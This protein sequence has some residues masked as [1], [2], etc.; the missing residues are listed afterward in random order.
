[1]RDNL[2]FLTLISAHLIGDFYLQSK[3][4]ANL[5]K[6]SLTMTIK[7]S[8]YYGIPFILLIL[9]FENSLGLLLLAVCIHFLVDGIKFALERK[10]KKGKTL[11]GL[12]PRWIYVID[13]GIHL[14]SLFFIGTISVAEL[15]GGI[16]LESFNL[17]LVITILPGILFLF[18]PANITFKIIFGGYAPLEKDSISISGAGAVIGSLE[19]ILM[20][21]FL[22]LNQ[23]AAVGLIMTAKSIARYDKIS[24]DPIFAEYYLIGTLYSILVTVIIYILFLL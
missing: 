6:D 14:L 13:Q 22:G 21:I 18:K 9:I 24:K 15:R 17:P 4:M 11:F 16:L 3:A 19:R 23:F 20:L 12:K 2:F 5:K 10:K 1:M 8:L 7:H